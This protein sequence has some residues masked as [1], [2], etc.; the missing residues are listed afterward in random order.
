M[1]LLKAFLAL[2]TL[3]WALAL[4]KVVGRKLNPRWA[5]VP[6]DPACGPDLKVSVIIPARNE[7]AHIGACVASV[8]AQ[9]HPNLEV[10]VM[11]DGSSDGT[12]DVLAAIDDPRLKVLSGGEALP[13]GWFGK[14]WALERAQRE[15]SGD[16]LFF[17][18]ADVRLHPHAV[19]RVVGYGHAQGLGM[20]TGFGTLVMETF[21]EK[22]LQP[23]VA[24]II[25]M[26]NDLDAVN[27]PEKEDK[28]MASGQLLA[29]SREGYEQAGRHESVQADIL[30]DVGL[31]RACV[32]NGVGYHC[33]FMRQLYRVRMYTSLS[34]IWQGWTKNLF[35]GVHYSWGV[36]VGVLT[37]LFT[38]T[39]LGLLVTLLAAAGVL[40]ADLLWWGLAQVV[41]MQIVR[42]VMDLI[43]EH[44]PVYGLSHAPATAFVMVMMVASGLKSRG[45]G[46]SWKGRTYKPG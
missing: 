24:G 21:W 7:E 41:V 10:I 13:D 4:A 45:S 6:E 42:G 5:L 2:I 39:H 22:V 33:L 26:G 23:A 18:D 29:F 44:N 3:G 40:P 12:G 1:L 38:T 19:S 20:V 11:N 15:A 36:V 14:P 35:A 31:A 8:L 28:N 25:L 34:E 9:D 32:A 37:Y 27:D 30:D 17:I 46:V 16:W 43:W